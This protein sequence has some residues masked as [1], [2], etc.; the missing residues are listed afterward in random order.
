MT[1][2]KIGDTVLWRDS[3]GDGKER[4]AKIIGIDRVVPGQRAGEEVQSISWDNPECIVVD[5]DVDDQW[6][7][8]YQIRPL[9]S[10]L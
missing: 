3:W 4:K 8:G 7:Y 6:A 5:L 9:N 1:D 2:L 10:N